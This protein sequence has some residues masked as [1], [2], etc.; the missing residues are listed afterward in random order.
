MRKYIRRHFIDYCHV[1]SW[2]SCF[3]N[4]LCSQTFL[5]MFPSTK[6][7]SQSYGKI[8]HSLSS[9]STRDYWLSNNDVRTRHLF[10]RA[11]R[12]MVNNPHPVTE[13][14][15]SSI[16]LKKTRKK[17]SGTYSI[18]IQNKS[19]FLSHFRLRGFQGSMF[20]C[21]W[22]RATI[23]HKMGALSFLYHMWCVAV[24]TQY[25]WEKCTYSMYLYRLLHVW[26]NGNLEL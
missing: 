19:E 2:N 17:L 8:G 9:N 20:S 23:P 1:T 26:R 21:Y 12:K 6:N 7:Q 25:T 11:V 10:A 14:R 22:T 13:K 3:W 18:L 5:Q 15:D 4:G 16:K 24:I